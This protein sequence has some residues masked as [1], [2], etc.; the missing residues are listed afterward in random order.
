MKLSENASHS[1]IKDIS[2]VPRQRSRASV[3]R[4]Q[5]LAVRRKLQIYLGHLVPDGARQRSI[6]ERGTIRG[7]AR[8]LIEVLN[9][10]PAVSKKEKVIYK[11]FFKLY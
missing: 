3:R 11:I 5:M 8:S 7:Q 2:E 9:L 10:F 1:G 6:R 4:V